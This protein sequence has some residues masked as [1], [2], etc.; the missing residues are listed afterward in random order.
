MRTFT[1]PLDR[2][3][4]TNDADQD[5]I[6]FVGTAGYPYRLLEIQLSASLL[7]DERLP[8]RF[9]RR[10]TTG[11]G[12]SALTEI[13]NDGGSSVPQLAVNTLVTTPGTISD[14]GP[15]WY[16]STLG[17][18]IWQPTLEQQMEMISGGRCALNLIAAVGGTRTWSGW[19][20][21]QEMG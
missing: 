15:C 4:V 17:P 12:G 18:M 10:T 7:T 5:I 3:S 16:W 1:A 2:I 11:S 8:L 9:V 6:E 13:K 14:I 19:A 21:W 20:T